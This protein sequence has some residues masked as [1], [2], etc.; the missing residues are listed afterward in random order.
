MYSNFRPIELVK[1]SGL[2]YLNQTLFALIYRELLLRFGV[3]KLGLV[4]ALLEPAVH[5]AILLVIFGSAAKSILSSE[6]IIL[7]AFIGVCGYLLFRTAVEKSSASLES[8]RV[9]LSFRQIT[10]FSLV[11]SRAIVEIVTLTIVFLIGIFFLTFY[12]SQEWNSFILFLACLGLLYILVIGYGLIIAV[13]SSFFPSIKK[14][15]S[16]FMRALYLL[17]GVFYPSVILSDTIFNY[18]SWNPLLHCIELMRQG[19]LG[20][21]VHAGISFYYFAIVSIFSLFLGLSLTLV[22]KRELEPS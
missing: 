20:V 16:F 21:D 12:L 9:L 14:F 10:P 19:L 2:F 4:W 6:Q 3:Y 7:F 1:K 17:S 5:V 15:N 18:L 13:T 8:S 22:F 11:F